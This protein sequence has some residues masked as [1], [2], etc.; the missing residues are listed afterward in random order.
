[1]FVT[2]CVTSEFLNRVDEQK[3]K[4]KMDAKNLS[5]VFGPALLRSDKTTLE[6][7]VAATSVGNLFV[8][9]CVENFNQIFTKNH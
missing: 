2:R 5:I 6:E 3:E 7:M 1:M 8:Q 4:N 9:K